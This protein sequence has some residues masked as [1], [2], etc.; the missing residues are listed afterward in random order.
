MAIRIFA[1]IDDFLSQAKSREEAAETS[2][3]VKGDL[4]RSG[5]IVCPEKT[6]WHPVQSGVISAPAVRMQKL[7]ERIAS[8]LDTGATTRNIAGVTYFCGVALGPG[9]AVD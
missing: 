9:K 3:Q 2:A 1:F 5:F 4:K 8:L 7:R 6:Q